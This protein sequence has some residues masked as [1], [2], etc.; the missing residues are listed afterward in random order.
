M[1][2]QSH[3]KLAWSNVMTATVNAGLAAGMFSTKRPAARPGLFSCRFHFRLDGVRA[4]A[5]VTDL[6][7]FDLDIAV[8]VQPVEDSRDEDA[9]AFDLCRVAWK[10]CPPVLCRHRWTAAATG[11][12]RRAYE[13]ILELDTCDVLQA[14]DEWTERLAGLSVTP[15]GYRVDAPT[16]KKV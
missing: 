1:S 5:L 4:F 12:F 10:E 11:T 15:L 8:A 9:L 16:R 14:G 13:P 7:V 6:P 3:R 2:H